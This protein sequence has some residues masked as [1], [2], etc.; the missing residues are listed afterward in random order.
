MYL[1]PMQEECVTQPYLEFAV[2]LSDCAIVVVVVLS[3]SSYFHN[4]MN[5]EVLIF[6]DALLAHINNHNQDSPLS[7]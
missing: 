2:V 3:G 4:G 1:A 5:G 6:N 7:L